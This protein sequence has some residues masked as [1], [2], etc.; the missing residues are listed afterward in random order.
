MPLKTLVRVLYI[1]DDPGICRLVQRHLERSGF[2][3]RMAY[4]AEIGL[5]MARAEPFDAIA[6]DHYMPG[7]DGLDVLADLRALPEAPPVIFVTAAEEP[8]IAVAA[9]KAGAF[10]YVIKDVQGTFLEFLSTSLAAVAGAYPA[11]AGEGGGRA[12]TAGK[13]GPA[14]EAGPRSRRCCCAR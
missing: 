7:R 1:D 12:R 13:P 10:D 5:A 11:A 6:L 14:G 8:R 3:V 9:L 2:E 4:E